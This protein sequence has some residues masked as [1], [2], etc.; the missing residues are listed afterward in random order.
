MKKIVY[1]ILILFTTTFPA[2]KT[3]DP[4]VDF[5]TGLVGEHEV[6]YVIM[7]SK[8]KEIFGADSLNAGLSTITF[9]KKDNNTLIGEVYIDEPRIKINE[10]FEAT[11]GANADTV[12]YN[13]LPASV[14]ELNSKYLFRSGQAITHLSLYKNKRIA[15]DITYSNSMGNRWLKFK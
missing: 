6:T 4:E 1:P 9:K 10:T 15:G 3:D 13:P 14:A 8:T 7:D 11:V 12:N 5:T 2:C